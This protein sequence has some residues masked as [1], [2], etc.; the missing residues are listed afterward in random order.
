VHSENQL[1][2][3]LLENHLKPP[4]IVRTR[5]TLQEHVMLDLSYTAD[6]FSKELESLRLDGRIH[7]EKIK[8]GS[9]RPT[10][11]YYSGTLDNDSFSDCKATLVERARLLR[12]R[13]LGRAGEYYARALFVRLKNQ[14]FPISNITKPCEL[15][16]EKLDEGKCRKDLSFRFQGQTRK[17]ISRAR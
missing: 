8:I 17:G 6:R 3:Y 13:D 5:R 10:H 7:R 1:L 14:G 9:Q 4:G 11:V 12:P 16:Y 15:G 2:N